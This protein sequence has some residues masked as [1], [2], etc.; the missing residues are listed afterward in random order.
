[1]EALEAALK[2]GHGR[3]NVHVAATDDSR[4]PSAP[5]A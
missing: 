3:V 5:T 2:V 4:P 1:M